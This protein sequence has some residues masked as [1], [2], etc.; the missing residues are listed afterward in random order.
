MVIFVIIIIDI[1]HILHLL[2]SYTITH[3]KL[4]SSLYTFACIVTQYNHKLCLHFNKNKNLLA[5]QYADQQEQYAVNRA[6]DL[7]ETTSEGL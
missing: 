7:P 3:K 5:S 1:T 6:L 4:I 2:T